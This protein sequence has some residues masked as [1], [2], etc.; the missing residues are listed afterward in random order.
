VPEKVLT[1]V[2][3]LAAARLSDGDVRG[4][5]GLDADA[6]LGDRGLDSLGMVGLLTDLEAHWSVELPPELVARET[7]ASARTV[8]AAFAPLLREVDAG[9]G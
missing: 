5:G 3:R 9:R 7:F 8:A 4:P 6:D 2:I 1:V